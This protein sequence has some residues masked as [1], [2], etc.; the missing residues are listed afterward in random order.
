MPRFSPDGKWIAFIGSYDGGQDIYV[1]P[2][3]GGQPQ[4]ITY[5]AGTE[6]VIGWSDNDTIMFA[7]NGHPF[8]NPLHMVSRKGGM[9]VRTKLLEITSGTINSQKVVAY[10]RVNSFVFNWRRYRGGTQGVVSFFDLKD[11]SYSEIPHDR[12]QQ[13]HPMWVGSQ[14]YYISDKQ[15]GTLNLYRYDTKSKRS[16]ML[17]KFNDMDI[18]FPST[19][20]KTIV[21]ERGGILSSYDIATGKVSSIQPR[22]LADLNQVRPQ[23]RKVAP[24]IFDL[25]L[26]PSAARVAVEARGD[27][28]TVP[29]KG[30]DTRNL[31][32]TQGVR[33][34]TPVWSPDGQTIAYISDAT[35]EF[36]IYTMPQ[37]GGKAT[38]ITSGGTLRATGMSWFPDSKKLLVF[39]F[40]GNLTIVDT[41]KKT[42][43]VIENNQLGF[44]GADISPQGDWI[45][46]S[47]AGAN[48]RNSVWL[49]NV[50]TGKKVQATEGYYADGSVAFD[51][52]GKYLYLVSGRTIS[53]RQNPSEINID[54]EAPD[55]VYAMLLQA[56][57]KNPFAS[58]EEDE[59]VKS[60]ETK[61]ADAPKPAD[62]NAPKGLKIDVEGLED[63][64]VVLPWPQGQYG[65]LIGVDNGVLV[66]TQGALQKFDMG[67]KQVSTIATGFGALTL[68]EARTK[69]AL[70]QGP[71][72]ISVN[73]VRPDIQ[74][75]QGAVST[76]GVEMV[77]DPRAEYKQMLNEAWRHVRDNFYDP[78]MVGVDWNGMKARYNDLI[79]FISTRNDLNY[80]L[81]MMIGE[82]GTGHAY[83]NPGPDF[84]AQPS[85]PVGMLGADFDIENG[86]LKVSAIFK[87]E[88]HETGQRG[89][90]AEPGVGVKVGDYLL[91]VDG[92]AV[93]SDRS[94]AEALI[95]KVNRGVVLTV[96]SVPSLTGARKVTVKPIANEDAIRYWDWV[97]DNRRKVLAAT[98]G[99][100]GY[101][102]VPNTAVEGIE[103]FIKGFYT[104]VDKDALIV[105]ERFNGGGFIPQ[106]FTDK[107]SVQARVGFKGRFGPIINYPVET[108]TPN[109]VMLINEYAGSG[110]DLFP[111]LYKDAKL[112][113][114]IGRRTWGG[115]VG[116][117]GYNQLVDG[118][119]VTAPSFGIF[120]P[121][122]GKWIAENTGVDPDIDVDARPDLLAKGQDPQL[123][124]AI[125]EALIR[126]KNG[127]RPANKVPAFPNTSGKK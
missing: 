79:P 81:G 63:R 60:A 91:E 62:A 97:Q 107:L 102:H 120:D 37:R 24:F 89:P 6:V 87:G 61:P 127:R 82:L 31:T 85:V 30:G 70:M 11:N 3:E 78:N 115:L 15:E 8:Y 46:Y 106:F 103:G 4:R 55:R 20:G 13:Y 16:E 43:K 72:Q 10:N 38:Q 83:V 25:T 96:N 101:M 86:K 39:E 14:V 119:G 93:G 23:M 124:R 117:Q 104:N 26:S 48:F 69:I 56:D 80:V 2:S 52:N 28:F 19:D 35:G 114:L 53:Y 40:N 71:G 27:I 64:M 50:E 41:E 45:A 73:D 47:A 118:G 33:E 92:K 112:G 9:P 12:E 84:F 36:E 99:K 32:D 110:G 75:G 108:I 123:D 22:I 105:D 42:T 67:S 113:P 18:R 59:P 125:K 100:V 88:G 95:G 74:P 44:G 66:L 122:T 121:R 54:M 116:I 109:T 98:G 34:K 5:E 17:T 21:F 1:I 57:T 65:T 111:W 90:L 49:Y 68:N 58:R 7:G 77:L 76:V 51:R 94:P 29:A 126:A